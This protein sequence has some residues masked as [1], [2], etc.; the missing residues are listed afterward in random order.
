MSD[1]SQRTE[2]PTQKRLEK[3]RKDGSFLTSKEFVGAIEFGVFLL[4]LISGAEWFSRVLGGLMRDLIRAAFVTSRELTVG[5]FTT[6]ARNLI[7][8]SFTGFLMAGAA[9][10]LIGLAVHLALTQFGFAAGQLSLKW[11]RLNPAVSSATCRV[12]TRQPC[13]KQRLY[14]RY[15]SILHIQILGRNSIYICARLVRRWPPVPDL[16]G[17]LCWGC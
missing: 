15:F 10:T 11:D 8:P 2:Q 6:L 9:M 7:F 17:T 1:S 4:I 13:S 14:S 12:R 5:D 16:F 3:A